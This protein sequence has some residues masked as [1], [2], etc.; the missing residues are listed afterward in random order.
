MKSG[1][2]KEKAEIEKEKT[3]SGKWQRRERKEYRP[4]ILGRKKCKLF[5]GGKGKRGKEKQK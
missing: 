5:G 2:Q 3:E 4:D 1:K